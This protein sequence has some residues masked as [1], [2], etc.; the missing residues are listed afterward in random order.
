MTDANVD[1]IETTQ[2]ESKR[3]RGRPVGTCKE[4]K[5]TSDPDY[6]KKYYLEKTKPNIDA[7][8]DVVCCYCKKTIKAISLKGHEKEKRCSKIRQLCFSNAL[9]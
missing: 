9:S 3:G 6:F 7:L 5:K 1:N 2:T 8:D 4:I